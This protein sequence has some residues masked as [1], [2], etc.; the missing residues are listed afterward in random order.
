[1][2][3]RSDV[4]QVNSDF[5]YNH[6][7]DTDA[8]EL[9]IREARELRRASGECKSKGNYEDLLEQVYKERKVLLSDDLSELEAHV[10]RW[11]RG[12]GIDYEYGAKGALNDLMYGG[13]QSGIVGH[14]IYYQDIVQFYSDHRREIDEMLTDLVRDTGE[15]P[16]ELFGDEWDAEDPFARQ[17]F[18]RN[19]LAWFGFEE[20]GRKLLDAIEAL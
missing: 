7:D 17:H 19:L 6:D 5:R 10:A 20:C 9:A 16:A 11:A 4:I 14:L 18:N 15:Q 13:C 3:T 1:M 12:M 8:A 2:I